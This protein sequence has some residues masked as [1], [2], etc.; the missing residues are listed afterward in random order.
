MLTGFCYPS[1]SEMVSPSTDGQQIPAV[2]PKHILKCSGS[3]RQETRGFGRT[4]KS[5]RWAER[6]F[7]PWG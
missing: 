4:E 1:E 6:C 2:L 7:N 5:G 3:M